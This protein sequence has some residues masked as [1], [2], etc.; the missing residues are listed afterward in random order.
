MRL[1]TLIGK[2]D[3]QFKGSDPDILGLALD[4]R[5]TEKGF[6]FAAIDG[7]KTKGNDY[8]LPALQNGA[9][10]ILYGGSYEIPE[11]FSNV[12]FLKSENPADDMAKIAAAY[13]PEQPQHLAAITGTNGKTSIADFVRQILVMQG[14]KAASIGT[15]GIIKNNEA[16]IPSPNTTPNCISIHKWLDELSKEGFSYTIMEASSHGIAQKR[17]GAARIKNA[18]FTNLTLDHLDYHK[19]ME[20]YYQ[21]KEGL[22]TK[23]LET[24]GIAVLN[25]D[26]DV[27]GRLREACL[28]SGKQ[29][30][31]YGINGDKIKL[32]KSEAL[33]KGQN[34]HIRFFGKEHNFYIPL[35]G[36]FQAMNVLCAMGLVAA[37]TGSAENIVEYVP[38]IKGAKGRMELVGETQG[39]AAVFVDYAHTPDA[40]ENT[41]RA[42]RE[43]TKAK[44]HVVF[45]CG[46]D[47]DNSKRPVM[48]QLA[49]ELAD[50]VYVAD[51]NPR[52][53][54]PEEI[55]RQIMA[56]CPHAQNIGNR[57][58]A[59]RL[60][61]AGLAKGDILL[62]AGKGHETGQ[63]IMGKVYP[64]SD[65][66]VILKY[67]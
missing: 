26:I 35:A 39:G 15:L 17:I 66:E 50:V 8:I 36:A 24:G 14:K 1:S 30:W 63:Y 65:Q 55:R 21:A 53:E 43:H 6:L 47:R 57:E 20:N 10:A 29:V 64:F 51:D 16:P 7:E 38:Q 18:G 13:Y 62:V 9:S 56:G 37:M 46:G 23:I 58:E 40:L 5:K 32:L 44:L 59:I 61:V 34:L 54:N 60:A 19:T 49:E 25:A 3:L 2:T 12:V 31:S 27:Y 67:L 45:G 52:T 48:G 33:P 28:K 4:S 41:L 11:G 22:F 42:L